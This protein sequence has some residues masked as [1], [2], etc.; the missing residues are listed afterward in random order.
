MVDWAPAAS[1][2][3]LRTVVDSCYVVSVP[4]LFVLCRMEESLHSIPPHTVSALGGTVG[5]ALTRSLSPPGH[6]PTLAKLETRTC[7]INDRAKT[8]CGSQE[9]LDVFNAVLQV[10]QQAPADRTYS[11]LT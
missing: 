2:R 9:E 11:Q 5:I 4:M 10:R 8:F 3:S 1:V 7:K 6:Q